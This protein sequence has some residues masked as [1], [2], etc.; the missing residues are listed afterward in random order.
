M[1]KIS[2]IVTCFNR[3]N[4]I[5]DCL[6]SV[7]WVDELVVVDSFSTDRTAEIAGRYAD[8]LLRHEYRSAAAQRNWAMERT[9][10]DWTL[11]IDSDEVM[12]PE[13]RDEIREEM[14]APR[15]DRYR[16]F[17]RGIFLGKEMRHGGWPRDTNN[18]LFRKSVYRFNDDEVHPLLLPEGACGCFTN[19]LIHYTHRS[20]DEFVSKSHTYAG[21]AAR[22]YRRR[23]RRGAF[24][25]IFTHPFYNFV[26]IYLLRAGFLD[27]ARG[28][29]SA[30]LSS[31]YV[32]EKY[33]RLWELDHCRFPDGAGNGGEGAGENLAHPSPPGGAEPELRAGKE[34]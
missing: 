27:G 2:G 9:S 34:S 18:I 24:G 33:A 7:D 12:P 25:K 20:I 4:E 31:A 10:H 22:K 15:Y 32:A 14:A 21:W 11:I 26:K 6:A 23:G 8:V 30:V 5:A 16:V 13:L 17:R 3:E 1:E 29:V 19:R 28:L